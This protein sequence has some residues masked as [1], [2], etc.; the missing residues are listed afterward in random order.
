MPRPPSGVES[1]RQAP[2]PLQA[3]PG[4]TMPARWRVPCDSSAYA[5][6]T[7]AMSAGPGDR[8][9][10]RPSPAPRDLRG[11]EG[12]RDGSFVRSAGPEAP[13]GHRRCSP[14]SPLPLMWEI[15]TRITDRAGQ[16]PAGRS[17]AAA[18]PVPG[19]PGRGCHVRVWFASRRP[20]RAWIDPRSPEA[21]GMKDIS[22]EPFFIHYYPKKTALRN[23]SF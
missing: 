8:P 20:H 22:I 18:F 19:R 21:C 13:C 23:D 10:A 12:V 4:S 16:K 5:G 6:P 2:R 15:E 7:R 3:L 11:H 1:H 9:P 17:P 14:I